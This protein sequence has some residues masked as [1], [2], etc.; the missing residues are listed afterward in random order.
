MVVRGPSVVVVPDSIR[1]RIHTLPRRFRKDAANGL[2][3]Q[4]LLHIGSDDFTVSVADH[5]CTVLEGAAPAPDTVVT[6]EPAAWIEIDEGNLTGGEA[7]LQHR[8]G[9]R[10][11]LDLA[12]RL[13]TLFRPASRTRRSSEMEQVE[14]VAD[15]VKLS[16]Y[17]IGRGTP[18]LMLHGL[19]GSKVSLFPLFNEL[20]EK[21]RLF[22]PDLPGHGE[23]DKPIADF[24]PRYYARVVRHLLDEIGAEQAVVLGNSLGGRVAL[25]L[26]LRSP[27]RVASL[28]LLGPAMPGLR[29]RYV[30]GFTRV[31]PSE[32]GAIP[33]PLRERWMRMVLRRLFSDPGHL[34]ESGYT[35]AAD[36]FIRIY[37]DP[38]ARVAFLA[39]LRSIVL[40]H[41]DPFFGSLRRIKQ[42][43]L[44][45][46]GAD[47][48]LV[49][50]RLGVRLAEHLPNA[51]SA[52]IPHTGHVPQLEATRQTLDLIQEFLQTAPSG[53]PRLSGSP[54][55]PRET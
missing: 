34:P 7:F 37:R 50:P 45:M 35:A 25:E 16:C 5:A 18:L 53:R 46:F 22:I 20:A 27:G 26:A 9:V 40:E 21:H 23:S 28:V 3:A 44:V 2:R 41:S 8:L 19:G 52:V 36:E 51:R 6:V 42:P 12:M 13:E 55:K 38:R 39:S 24:T 49:P 29:W 47:D 43:T 14:F 31:F 11:N 4:W 17:V 1:G 15:G 10:G 30:L 54:L 33:F 32:F 48:H